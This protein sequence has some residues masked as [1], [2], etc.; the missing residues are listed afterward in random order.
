MHLT[1][2]ARYSNGW[3]FFC[4][5]GLKNHWGYLYR[6]NFLAYNMNFFIAKIYKEQTVYCRYSMY[7]VLNASVNKITNHT[8]LYCNTVFFSKF[9]QQLSHFIFWFMK[10]IISLIVPQQQP[11]QAVSRCGWWLLTALGLQFDVAGV[12]PLGLLCYHEGA[13]LGHR[14]R[15]FFAHCNII[16]I[17]EW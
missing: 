5:F 2:R 6:V 16:L 13:G 4:E 9:T 11:N 3:T 7:K 1:Q 12:A 8:S 14:L 10:N 15:C 17:Y